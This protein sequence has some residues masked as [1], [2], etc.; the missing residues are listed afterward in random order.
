M[1]KFRPPNPVT[2][3][4]TVDDVIGLIP[5]LAF[6]KGLSPIK[7][8]VEGQSIRAQVQSKAGSPIRKGQLVCM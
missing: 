8:A 7:K 1:V 6:H 2:L 3:T 4:T 5:A